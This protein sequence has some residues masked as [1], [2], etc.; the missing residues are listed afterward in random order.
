MP[1]FF[2]VPF[3]TPGVHDEKDEDNKAEDEKN[4]RSGSVLPELL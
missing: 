2:A 1:I 3:V 4:E